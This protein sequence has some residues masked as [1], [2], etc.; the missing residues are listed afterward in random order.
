MHQLNVRETEAEANMDPLGQFK[1]SKFLE[2]T[3]FVAQQGLAVYRSPSFIE[4]Q[5]EKT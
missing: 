3:F 4:F 2:Q 1:S 5:L